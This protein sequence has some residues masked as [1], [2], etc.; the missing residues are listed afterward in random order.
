[1]VKERLSALTVDGARRVRAEDSSKACDVR[2]RRETVKVDF[3][4]PFANILDHSIMIFLLKYLGIKK[5]FSFKF[6]YL[7]EE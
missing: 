6:V 4:N 7:M 5:L 3:S 1:M 2:R